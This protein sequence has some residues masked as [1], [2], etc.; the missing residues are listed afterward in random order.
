MACKVV[1]ARPERAADRVVEQFP[2][3]DNRAFGPDVLNDIAM[4]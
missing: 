3:L 4:P 2:V 1:T